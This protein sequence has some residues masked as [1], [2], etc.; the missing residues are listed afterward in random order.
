MGDAARNVTQQLLNVPTGYKVA[1]GRFMASDPEPLQPPVSGGGGGGTVDPGIARPRSTGTS[2]NVQ[3]LYIT[4]TSEAMW[5]A[6]ESEALRT[7]GRGVS[8]IS[9]NTRR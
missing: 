4:P 5:E 6:V 1:L 9:T 2:I 3:N 7:A 8:M